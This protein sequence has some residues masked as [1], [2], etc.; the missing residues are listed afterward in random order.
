MIMQI[1]AAAETVIDGVPYVELTPWGVIL[2]GLVAF[3]RGWIVPR[4]ALIDER[5]DTKEWRAAHHLSEK[6]REVNAE[7]T[8]LLLA[9]AETA[10]ALLESITRRAKD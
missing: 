2:F 8:R 9:H 5:E 4:Q 3:M 7:Q 6:A 10:N 1:L